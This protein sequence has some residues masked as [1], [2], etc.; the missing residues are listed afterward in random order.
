ML[1]RWWNSGS[2]SSI[3]SSITSQS[4]I[5]SLLIYLQFF[6]QFHHFFSLQEENPSDL[7]RNR[8]SEWLR[9]G[10]GC[11]PGC[12]VDYCLLLYI[13]RCQMDRQSE[14][15][16]IIYIKNNIAFHWCWAES[17]FFIFI[18]CLFHC[19]LPLCG[20]DYYVNTGRDFARCCRWYNL[21]SE[22][23]LQQITYSSGK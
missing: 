1:T 16:V 15:D 5:N 13:S 6:Y 4:N 20:L 8:S 7:T 21:L 10:T 18:G 12:Y 9:L 11:L 2:M 14:F 22:A 3:M 19:H 23:R 17:I